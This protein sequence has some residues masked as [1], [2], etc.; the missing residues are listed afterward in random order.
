MHT[1]QTLTPGPSPTGI[2]ESPQRRVR[3]IVSDH[4][5]LVSGILIDIVVLSK[6]TKRKTTALSDTANTQ[7]TRDAEVTYWL[8]LCSF[9]FI[10]IIQYSAAFATF[11]HTR[12]AIAVNELCRDFRKRTLQTNLVLDYVRLFEVAL[13]TRCV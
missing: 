13:E 1:I 10:I 4:L 6:M 3:G 8:A 11:E 9:A 5:N 7:T 12:I 2:G